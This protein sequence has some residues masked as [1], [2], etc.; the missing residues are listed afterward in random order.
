MHF[1][2]L[3]ETNGRETPDNLGVRM[4]EI[5]AFLKSSHVQLK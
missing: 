4:R 1:G 3:S 2:D 5:F